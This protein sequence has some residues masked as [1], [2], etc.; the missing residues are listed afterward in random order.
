MLIALTKNI[1]HVITRLVLKPGVAHV[2]LLSDSLL[3][4]AWWPLI[5]LVVILLSILFK[6][7][8]CG[9]ILIF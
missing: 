5:V 8:V 3:P 2:L 4:V 9:R 7:I 6:S 1:I